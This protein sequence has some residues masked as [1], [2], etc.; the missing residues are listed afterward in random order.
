MPGG[1]VAADIATQA[2]G[3]CSSVEG[4][5]GCLNL[6]VVWPGV[7]VSPALPVRKNPA[8]L[9]RRHASDL[10]LAADFGVSAAGYSFSRE[11]LC[12][13]VPVIF[14]PQMAPDMDDQNRRAALGAE[15]MR[16]WNMA[17]VIDAGDVALLG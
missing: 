3:V 1:G 12:N 14:V 15:L 5:P 13:A 10:C 17:I 4:Q 9:P 11:C 6:I 8:A 7:Q 16:F 2:T